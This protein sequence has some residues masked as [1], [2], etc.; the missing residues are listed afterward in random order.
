MRCWYQIRIRSEA[1]EI[2]AIGGPP[3]ARETVVDEPIVAVLCNNAGNHGEFRLFPTLSAWWTD[4]NNKYILMT[5][6]ALLFILF[7]YF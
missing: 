3:V 7:I 4:S 5:K 1:T 2:S 6:K